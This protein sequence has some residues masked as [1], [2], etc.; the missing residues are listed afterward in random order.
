MSIH[1]LNTYAVRLIAP[2]LPAN[3]VW[4]LFD[5]L[6]S[7][8]LLG[9]VVLSERR[10]ADHSVAQIPTVLGDFIPPVVS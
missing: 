10:A 4:Q 3:R 5:L 7:G 9:A 1:A 2:A 8:T 6:L